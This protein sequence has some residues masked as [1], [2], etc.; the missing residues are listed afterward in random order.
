[1]TE[2]AK[3]HV[4]LSADV[5]R[6]KTGLNTAKTELT[7][8]KT[9][10]AGLRKEFDNKMGPS[11]KKLGGIFSSTTRSIVTGF[12]GGM[13]AVY[14]IGQ[15]RRAVSD[16]IST[17]RDFEREWANVTTMLGTSASETDNL[18]KE[19]MF[20]SP[21]LGD[22]TELAKGMY[23][24]LS[25]SIEP[26]KAVRFLGEAAK[27]AKAGVTEAATAVDAL[28]TVINAYGMEAEAVTDVS[29]IMFQAVKSG[30]LTYEQLAV[31]LGTVVPVAAQ[32]GVGFDEIA[33]AVATLTR[34]GIDAQTATMQLRQV[35]MSVIKPSTGA[36]KKAKELGLEFNAS[37]LKAK[38]LSAF[39]AELKEKTGGN[40]EALATLVPNVRALTSVMALAGDQSE[41]YA[42]DLKKMAS[43]SGATEEAFNKQKK[44]IDFMA[45][46]AKNSFN[47]IK[48][49]FYDGLVDPFREGITSTEDLDETVR[50]L[51]EAFQFLGKVIGTGTKAMFG[52]WID[53]VNQAN[54]IFKMTEILVTG[55][56]KAI[57]NKQIPTLKN[58]I[59][60][61]AEHNSTQE[62]AI[63]WAK[64]HREELTKLANKLFGIKEK[65]KE[66]AAVI[67]TGFVPALTAAKKI[68]DTFIPKATVERV[69][70]MRDTLYEITHIHSPWYEWRTE[71]EAFA[72]TGAKAMGDLKGVM[73][74]VGYDWKNV[75]DD[76]ARAFGDAFADM[77]R[78]AKNFGDFMKGIANGILNVFS[79]ALGKLVTEA[80]EP[81]MEEAMASIKSIFSTSALS[82]A[83]SIGMIGLSIYGVIDCISTWNDHYNEFWE[84]QKA[85][86]DQHI[87]KLKELGRTA[88]EIED[89][90][91][92]KV[93][94]E[95]APGRGRGGPGRGPRSDR[96][97]KPPPLPDEIIPP[98]WAAMWKEAQEKGLA[99][100]VE[101]IRKAR[102]EGGFLDEIQQYIK[103]Q[104][105]QIPSELST[106]VKNIQVEFKDGLG[107]RTGPF[108]GLE[109]VSKL[110]QIAFQ[111]M[112]AEGKS[113]LETMKE[114][115]GPLEAMKAKYEKIGKAV[116][117]YLQPMFDLMDTMKE[118]PKVFENLDASRSILDS[119][120]K[121]TYLT[122]DA[123]D[124][125]A[126]SVSGAAR[127]ILGISGSDN[128]NQAMK[129]LDMTKTQIAQML[130]MVSQ[131]VGAAATFGLKTPEWM[132]TFVEGQAGIDWKDF[133]EKSSAQANAGINTVKRIEATNIKLGN[134]NQKVLPHWFE[135]VGNQ[136]EGAIDGLLSPLEAIRDTLKKVK[137][138]ATGY[139]GTVA[140]PTMMVVHPNEQID[141]TPF[142]TPASASA[143]SG[144]STSVTIN[145]KAWDARSVEDWLARGGART[146]GKSVQAGLSGGQITVPIRAVGG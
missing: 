132:R 82:M 89:I 40:V 12:I 92:K 108:K 25:A 70:M 17:G 48:V 115:Q 62:K 95:D 13:G 37:A 41:A 69:Q 121:S 46:T 113:Y 21:T 135:A 7:K 126:Q 102:E 77:I 120:A 81:V 109:R 131:F 24:V 26:A 101:F 20:L 19:L 34:Q 8:L 80:L 4:T 123:F 144:G 99:S 86:I 18:K 93:Y 63:K 55:S 138:H 146:I 145:V 134:L 51:S 53:K 29:D 76:M 27:S 28:T 10:T 84:E 100:I 112:T 15:A 14:A 125:L 118:R 30:K 97:T 139:H 129:T 116:P 136:I 85:N 66:A 11:T 90:L 79:T 107:G 122:Q 60:A 73:V 78:T 104:L 6:L 88:F 105:A 22:T 137:G 43:A 127:A 91:S 47:K 110:A 128:L 94:G 16:L 74:K 133:K 36:A 42:G 111:A 9:S 39:L 98:D 38:G 143:S 68:T 45:E 54:A 117:K 142:N 106:L 2:I 71:A 5:K 58:S 103:A 1:L 124:A 52:K 96:G 119:L 59:R 33:A 56:A 32:V 23:Q 83:T 50:N 72:G 114:M 65:T 75:S 31:S 141:I 140:S 61:W 49:A 130:P 57:Q 3:L 87:A 67:K 64:E 35:I 44:S